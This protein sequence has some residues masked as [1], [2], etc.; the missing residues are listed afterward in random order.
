VGKPDG[1]K[2]LGRIILKLKDTQNKM[3][4][5]VLGSRSSAGRL[6]F[7]PCEND[8]GLSVRVKYS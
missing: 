5:C 6:V 2:T 4:Y 7:G 1:K 8:N 3:G